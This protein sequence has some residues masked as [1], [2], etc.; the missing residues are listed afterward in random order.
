VAEAVVVMLVLVLVVFLGIL[1]ISR[2]GF[3]LL[4]LFVESVALM[5]ALVFVLAVEEVADAVV[6]M[7]PLVLLFVV[8]PLG[9][10]D[11]AWATFVISMRGVQVA[12]VKVISLA[13]V[14]VLAVEEVADAVVVMALVVLAITLIVTHMSVGD[15]TVL[16]L[17]MMMLLCGVVMTACLALWFKQRTTA[18]F[19]ARVGHFCVFAAIEGLHRGWRRETD[20]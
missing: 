14:L 7:L 1:T 18:P 3:M 16:V 10:L 2:V 15:M 6:V 12:V 8:L 20:I 11:V 17:V 9:M 5:I 13:L 19:L 4:W